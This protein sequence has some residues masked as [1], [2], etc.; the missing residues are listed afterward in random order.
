MINGVL[1]SF[2]SVFAFSGREMARSKQTAIELGEN[3]DIV[4]SALN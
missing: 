2:Q 4:I 3:G 1:D